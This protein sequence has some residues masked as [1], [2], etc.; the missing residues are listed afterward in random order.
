MIAF[1][2]LER[3]AG[4][5]ILSD[6]SIDLLDYRWEAAVELGVLECCRFV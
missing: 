4:E 1:G 2:A 6:V 5:V 3:G